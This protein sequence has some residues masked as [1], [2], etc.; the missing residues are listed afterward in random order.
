VPII[1]YSFKA[2]VLNFGK[3]NSTFAESSVAI[4]QPQIGG[5]AWSIRNPGDMTMPMTHAP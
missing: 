1:K 3:K 2:T 4:Y 5:A